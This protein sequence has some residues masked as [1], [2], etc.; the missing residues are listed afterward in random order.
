[1]SDGAQWAESRYET[2]K[3]VSTTVMFEYRKIALWIVV[4]L[5]PG[6]IL[7]LP[8]LLADVRKH[9]SAQKPVPALPG[10]KPESP[11]DGSDPNPRTPDDGAPPRLAA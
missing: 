1:M 2:C 4:L 8:F 11:N 10:E 7:L 3:N 6:G 5:V 9:A